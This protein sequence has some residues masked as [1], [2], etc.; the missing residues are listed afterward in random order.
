MN[1]I[2]RTRA[3]LAKLEREQDLKR[4]K[5]ASGYLDSA[6]ETLYD[7]FSDPTITALSAQISEVLATPII[8]IEEILKKATPSVG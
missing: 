1:Q 5:M 2:D 8:K 7:D 4:L 6:L 3:K